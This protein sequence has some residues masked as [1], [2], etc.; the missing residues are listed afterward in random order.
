MTFRDLVPATPPNTYVPRIFGYRIHQPVVPMT[1]DGTGGAA[2]ALAAPQQ[3][4]ETSEVLELREEV[5]ALRL[6]LAQHEAGGASA[7]SQPSFPPGPQPNMSKAY[8]H[9]E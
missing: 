9:K 2:P 3:R 8:T 5:A 4:Q 1:A 7:P 6:R